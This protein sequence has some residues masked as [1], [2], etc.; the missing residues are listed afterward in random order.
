MSNPS[1]LAE[2][3]V[4]L[5]SLS[6]MCLADELRNTFKE[7]IS[8]APSSS[9]RQPRERPSSILLVALTKMNPSA[10]ETLDVKRTR[11]SDPT[12]EGNFTDEIIV[13]RNHMIE[14]QVLKSIC[15]LLEY[16]EIDRRVEC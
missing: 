16:A 3:P 11:L 7:D 4:F 12:T 10:N 6:R 8:F 2:I 5:D 13:I 14:L 9:F 1:N 15:E